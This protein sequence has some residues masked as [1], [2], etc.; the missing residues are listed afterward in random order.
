MGEWRGKNEDF[1]SLHSPGKA[2]VL[3][4]AAIV[5]CVLTISCYIT[6]GLCHRS[7]NA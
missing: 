4:G 5:L 6:A 1:K 2:Q 3:T 7:L